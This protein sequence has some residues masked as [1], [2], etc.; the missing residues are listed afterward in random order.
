[1]VLSVKKAG[2]VRVSRSC[3]A[4]DSLLA[5]QAGQNW[6]SVDLTPAL[7]MMQE[8][9][10]LSC[11]RSYRVECYLNGELLLSVDGVFE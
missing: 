4:E 3:D 10:A 5:Q 7:R 6:F 9:K 8:E 1:M 11:G 2:T